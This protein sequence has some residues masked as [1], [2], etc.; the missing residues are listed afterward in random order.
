MNEKKASIK[1]R[2]RA[3]SDEVFRN[4]L[5]MRLRWSISALERRRTN[6]IKDLGN[7]VFR[8]LQRK[9]I[10]I[11]ET[12]KIVKIIQDLELKIE[13][14]E[15]R[16]RDII[17][18][19]DLPKQ[20]SDATAEKEQPQPFKP[21]TEVLASKP[22]PTP[23]PK[24]TPAPSPK[25]APVPAD[26]PSPKTVVTEKKPKPAQEIKSEPAMAEGTQKDVKKTQDKI[27]DKAVS[28]NGTTKRPAKSK[29]SKASSKETKQLDNLA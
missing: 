25:P 3:F 7:R 21:K 13:A 27:A 29:N 5:I 23:T 4:Y 18:K 11:P 17:M 22:T 12:D 19:A 15:E 6:E 9:E 20:L 14:Q 28:K 16:L 2:L 24:P 1:N 10:V 26:S 8:L